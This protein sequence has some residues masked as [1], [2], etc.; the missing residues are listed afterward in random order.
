VK[1]IF[2]N[3]MSQ[4]TGNP[5]N[6]FQQSRVAIMV[7]FVV[8]AFIVFGRGFGSEMVF[9]SVSIVGDDPRVKTF[10]AQ[11]VS[12]I[13][14]KSYWWPVMD[15]R[16]YRPLPKLVFLVENA[17]LGFGKEPRGYQLVNLLLHC[18]TSLVALSLLRRLG[19]GQRVAVVLSL[20]FMV[21]PYSVEVV[22]N[23]VGLL[24]ILALLGMLGAFYFYLDIVEGRCG[25]LRGGGGLLLCGIGALLSKENA[26]SLLAFIF[27]HACTLGKTN[28][29]RLWEDKT[30]RRRLLLIISACFLFIV[31]FLLPRFIF[32]T[33]DDLKE[34]NAIHNPLLVLSP[35]EA[36]VNAL[37]IM[38]TN[39]VNCVVPTHISADYSYNQV[40]LGRLPPENDG[41]WETILMAVSVLAFGA[42]GL[43]LVNKAPA[44]S[45]AIGAV[46]IALIPTSN[47]LV[48]IGTI[49]ADR[50]VYPAILPVLVCAIL[51]ASK[52]TGFVDKKSP[53]LARY[54]GLSGQAGLVLMLALVAAISHLRCADWR[55][56]TPFWTAMYA[57]A[58]DS[59]KAKQSYGMTLCGESDNSEDDFNK[60]VSLLRAAVTQLEDSPYKQINATSRDTKAS[61]AEGLFQRA[62]FY[63][64]K[65]KLELAE[66]DAQEAEKIFEF[67]W[68]EQMASLQERMTG[69]KCKPDNKWDKI[70][71]KNIVRLSEIKRFLGRARET[72][73]AMGNY[74]TKDCFAFVY[75]FFWAQA[76]ANVDAGDWKKGF[77]CIARALLLS[78]DSPALWEEAYWIWNYHKLPEWAQPSGAA[79]SIAG[80]TPSVKLDLSDSAIAAHFSN[81]ANKLVPQLSEAKRE[82]ERAYIMRLLRLRLGGIN[83]RQF[84]G[85]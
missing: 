43:I 29:T 9:D 7:L 14:S 12:D 30:G 26:F 28:I 84:S 6:S 24:D 2:F 51:F 8:I 62:V 64:Q 55:A 22:P 42:A 65:D 50:L 68:D 1:A 11:S 53:V 57:T 69:H 74:E 19:M 58:P 52:L 4:E 72:A 75:E 37:S 35:A 3:E 41:D 73:D 40:K 79:E 13:L 5:S 16:E 71:S 85:M 82:R 36:R 21:H 78:S 70:D 10:S 18:I 48:I 17:I 45:F 56:S 80:S 32:E 81:A 33:E 31:V 20:F 25:L 63:K 39:I 61:L 76:R 77:S 34:R 67:L 49:K 44:I 38:G 27:W 15:V 59:F 46:F 23:I 60:G 47:T 54:L 83:H 66:R